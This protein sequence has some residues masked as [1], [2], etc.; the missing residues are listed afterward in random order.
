MQ[1][2]LKKSSVPAGMN[3]NFAFG[4]SASL[5][6]ACFSLSKDFKDGVADFGG[7]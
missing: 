6:G 2:I 7:K 4:V 1:H 5:D 3:L